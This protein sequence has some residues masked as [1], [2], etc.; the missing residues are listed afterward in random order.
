VLSAYSTDPVFSDFRKSGFAGAL[1]K[2][3]KIEA[4][5]KLI[6]HLLKDEDASAPSLR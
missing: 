3:F 4:F 2:P 1:Q 6:D 5:K